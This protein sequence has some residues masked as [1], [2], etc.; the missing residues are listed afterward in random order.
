MDADDRLKT[1]F[2]QDEPPA[3]DPAFSAAVMAEIARRRF[4]DDV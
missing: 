2:A 3:R 1:L 4:L